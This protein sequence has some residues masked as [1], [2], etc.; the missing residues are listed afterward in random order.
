M[1]FVEWGQSQRKEVQT[2]DQFD[3]LLDDVASKARS[4]A[5]PQGVQVTVGDA[6]TLSV[7]VGANR[8]ILNHIPSHLN[9]PY[10]ISLGGGRR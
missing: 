3:A 8:S 9:P 6:G 7:V 10:M 2:V 1:A 4:E 5:M